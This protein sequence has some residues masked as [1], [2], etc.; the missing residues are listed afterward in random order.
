MDDHA[1]QIVSFVNTF[2]E[3]INRSD[4]EAPWLGPDAKELD[5]MTALDFAQKKSENQVDEPIMTELSRD[6][7]GVEANELSTLYMVDYIKSGTGL[8]NIISDEKNGAQYLRNRRG[9]FQTVATKSTL[10][11]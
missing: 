6:L 7:L 11:L 10:T 3:C 4:F 1:T 5:S 9:M 8:G 2:G